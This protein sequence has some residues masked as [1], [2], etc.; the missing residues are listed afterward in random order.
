MNIALD[1]LLADIG[2]TAA[3]PFEAAETLPAGA[4]TDPEFTALEVEH[5]F[6]RDWVCVGRGDEIAQPGDY[7]AHHIVDAPVAVVRQTDGSLKGV[8]QC[9][10]PPLGRASERSRPCGQNR[11]P[12]SRLVL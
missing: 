7:L 4:Y 11:L 1:D 3:R 10:P 9:L 6:R 2:R 12:L 8:C 5:L